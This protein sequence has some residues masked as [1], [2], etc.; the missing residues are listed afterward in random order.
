MGSLVMGGRRRL[1]SKGALDIT[2]RRDGRGEWREREKDKRLRTV[3][4]R[5]KVSGCQLS[6]VGCRT[7]ATGRV[8]G[9][10]FPV[11]NRV[12]LLFGCVVL[13]SC[14][15]DPV[16]WD[17][18]RRSDAPVPAGARLTLQGGDEPVMAAA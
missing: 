6:V 16:Q 9:D 1:P 4:H 18:E 15:P 13:A 11:M 12:Y 3:S 10:Y 8:E 2:E 14:A 5:I 17:S 7:T